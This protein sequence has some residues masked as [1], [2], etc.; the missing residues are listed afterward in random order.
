MSDHLAVR[1][2]HVQL[3]AFQHE[4]ITDMYGTKGEGPE[5]QQRPEPSGTA[6]T[7]HHCA[8]VRHKC[9][10]HSLRIQVTA[11]PSLTG[12]ATLAWHMAS[13]VPKMNGGRHA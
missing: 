6:S 11:T 7:Q 1:T 8:S 13:P 9:H 2:P 4:R 10:E 5:A 12:V 3:P